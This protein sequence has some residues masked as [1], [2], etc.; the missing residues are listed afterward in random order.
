M[1]LRNLIGVWVMRI[2]IV[3]RVKFCMS[4]NVRVEWDW[5]FD[6]KVEGLFVEER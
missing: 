2:E 5:W 3:F 4:W 6:G 1:K